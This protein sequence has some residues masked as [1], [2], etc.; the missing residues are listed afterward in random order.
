LAADCSFQFTNIDELK[1][2]VSTYLGFVFGN[3]KMGKQRQ[4][5]FE[6]KCD[7]DKAVAKDLTGL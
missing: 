7:R 3:C 5:K 2:E 4:I 6:A 1:T